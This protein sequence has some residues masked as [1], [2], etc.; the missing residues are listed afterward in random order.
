MCVERVAANRVDTGMGYY[1]RL[2]LGFLVTECLKLATPTKHLQ[3][4]K[5]VTK[6]TKLLELTDEMKF[7]VAVHKSSSHR[8]YSK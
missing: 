1:T 2:T 4:T 7:I 6:M 8:L 3:H 5:K